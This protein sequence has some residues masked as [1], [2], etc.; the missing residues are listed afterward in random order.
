[1]KR[2]G[3]AEDIAE[4]AAFLLSGKSSWITGQILNVDGGIST[5]KTS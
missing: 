2:I 4:V 3:E 1:M 5:I